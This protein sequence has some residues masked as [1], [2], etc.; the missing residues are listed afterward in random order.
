MTSAVSEPLRRLSGPTTHRPAAAE[1]CLQGADRCTHHR[2]SDHSG[3]RLRVA[4]TFELLIYDALRVAWSGNEPS[5]RILLVGGTETDVEDFDWPLRDG[6]LADCW[7]G[8]SAG[9]QELS[10]STYIATSPSRPARNGSPRFSPGTGNRLDLQAPGGCE[11]G[12]P[13]PG[14][15]TRTDRAVL[16][17]V[18]SDSGNVSGAVCCT[19]MTV[20][21]ITPVWGWPWP[22]AISLPMISPLPRRPPSN[23]AWAGLDHTSRPAG[24]PL[25]SARQRGIPDPSR[26]PRRPPPFSVQERRRYPAQ[27]RCG[28]TRP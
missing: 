6:E 14:S 28:F 9:S 26:L 17:D 13:A 24:A 27:R 15:R 18:V 10:V 1:R 11:A 8:S 22:W 20:S 4:A 12:D 16:A 2:R 3:S 7:S 5:T 25:H 21:T 19:P 23:C